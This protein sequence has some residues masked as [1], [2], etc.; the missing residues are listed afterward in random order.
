MVDET[1][2]SLYSSILYVMEAG[3]ISVKP[4]CIYIIITKTPKY[5]QSVSYLIL[6][7]LLWTFVGNLLFTLGHPLPMLPAVCFRMDGVVGYLLKTELQRSIY[8]TVIVAA[9]LNCAL[10][11][12]LT[13]LY[14]YVT[15]AY[16]SFTSQLNKAW[17]YLCFIIAHLVLSL[18]IVYGIYIWRLPISEYPVVD[19]PDSTRNLFCY[20]PVGIKI[21]IVF[22]GFYA[23]LGAA[24]SFILLLGGLSVREL[25]TK[26]Q[27][28]EKTTLSM[29][30]EVLKNLLI[31]TGVAFFLGDIPL[32]ILIFYLYN[33]K[34]PFARTIASGLMLCT[35]NFGTVYALVIL[36]RFKPY[37]EAFLDLARS[38][39][40]ILRKL[41][42]EEKPL[43]SVSS[44][45]FF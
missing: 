44:H 27:Y 12:A 36:V 29:Q 15:I 45:T 6:N 23:L 26:S 25:R 22:Y 2:F 4:L 39:R 32:F 14:R 8:F 42:R 16:S 24:T 3:N 1:F 9:A 13:F 37:R 30:K 17:C 33:N 43:N 35:V 40:N 28:M 41:V 20:H 21:I 19:L 31:T 5:M 18:I 34:L 11:F 10:A 7:E 38:A